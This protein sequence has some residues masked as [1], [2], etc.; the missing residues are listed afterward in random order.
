MA[1]TIPKNPTVPLFIFVFTTIYGRFV[2]ARVGNRSPKAFTSLIVII[3]RS[4]SISAS[5]C[6]SSV[7]V[8]RY[9]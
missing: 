3:L 7:G 8:I 6:R 9:S 4:S 2:R 5:F 1:E